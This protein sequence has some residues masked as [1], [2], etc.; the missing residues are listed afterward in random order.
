MRT[1]FKEL[2]MCIREIERH[3][4]MQLNEKLNKW[5]RCYGNTEKSQGRPK[6]VASAQ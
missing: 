5:R 1:A 6:Q 2:D 4:D 3:G